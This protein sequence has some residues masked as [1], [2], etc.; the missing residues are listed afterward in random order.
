M[1]TVENEGSSCGCCCRVARIAALVCLLIPIVGSGA[2]LADP[3]ELDDAAVS[4]YEDTITDIWVEDYVY[5]SEGYLDYTSLDVLTDPLH[6]DIV[7]DTDFGVFDYT[8]DTDYYGFDHFTYEVADEYAQ[9]S[10]EVIVDIYVEP[11]DGS[12][13]NVAPLLVDFRSELISGNSWLLSGRVIDEYPDGLTVTFGGLLQGDTCT[14]DSYGNFSYT[15]TI[16]TTGA[17]TAD[18]ED[19]DELLSNEA[20]TY[21]NNN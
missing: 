4:T 11:D 8:P 16:T 14:T 19:D 6:G 2:L 7:I 18:T 17:V 1:A 12:I 5:Y 3:P 21:V 9:V 13:D 15:K 10:A 20:S